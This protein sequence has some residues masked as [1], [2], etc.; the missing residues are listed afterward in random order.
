MLEK[1]DF[2]VVLHLGGKFL[3]PENSELLNSETFKISKTKLI[4]KSFML[5]IKCIFY[6]REE[7]REAV[8]KTNCATLENKEAEISSKSVYDLDINV[9]ICV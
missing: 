5:H 4:I 3:A 1:Q 8:R 9:Y 7:E 2:V 6:L